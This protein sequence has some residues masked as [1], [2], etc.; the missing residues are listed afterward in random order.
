MTESATIYS[1][2]HGAKPIQQLLDELAAANI[3]VVIDARSLPR[4]RFHPQY[5]QKS[6]ENSLPG[7]GI[8]YEWQ[9]SAIG[10]KREN[11]GYEEAMKELAKRAPN[12]RIALM[13]SERDYRSCHR[14]TMLEPTLRTYGI[15]MVH[16]PDSQSKLV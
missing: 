4:S 15:Q 11:I 13:C 12:E 16:L 1:I 7:A 5:N 2:G 9:G 8:R 6:L 10:G 3:E 14:H